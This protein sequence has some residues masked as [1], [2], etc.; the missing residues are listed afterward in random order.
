MATIGQETY[1]APHALDSD[2]PSPSISVVIPVYNEAPRLGEL[3]SR[4]AATLDEAGRTFELIFVDD[5]SIDGTLPSSNGSTTRTSACG[6]FAS[7]GTSVSTRRC[8]QASCARVAR[9]G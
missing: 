8:T 6:R 4:T 1:P 9:S 5:G 2:A 7:S 3:Y